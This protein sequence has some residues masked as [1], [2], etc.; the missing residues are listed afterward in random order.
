MKGFIMRNGGIEFENLYSHWIV[1]KI[2]NDVQSIYRYIISI[3][4]FT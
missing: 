4:P 3:D 1:A 2:I